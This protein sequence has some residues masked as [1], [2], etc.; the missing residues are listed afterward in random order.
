MQAHVDVEERVMQVPQGQPH[1]SIMS[2]AGAVYQ[3]IRQSGVQHRRTQRGKGNGK[4]HPVDSPLLPKQRLAGR[5]N[6]M[7]ATN[8]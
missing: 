1:L 8:R 7:G 2:M 5:S 6:G 4:D 3:H